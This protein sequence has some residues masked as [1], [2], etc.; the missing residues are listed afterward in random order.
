MP[1]CSRCP[2]HA[3]DSPKF[4]FSHSIIILHKTLVMRHLKVAGKVT[5]EFEIAPEFVDTIT[6]ILGCVRP[7]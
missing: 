4:E 6:E 1:R 7:A 2:I 5:M 3:S